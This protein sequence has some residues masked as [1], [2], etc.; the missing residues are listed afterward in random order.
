MLV[1]SRQTHELCKGETSII[2]KD[3]HENGA[4]REAGLREGDKLISVNG[5]SL[6]NVDHA[7]AVD[8][9]KNE[10]PSQVISR[11]HFAIISWHNFVVNLFSPKNYQL[12]PLLSLFMISF[13]PF[14]FFI[15]LLS[16]LLLFSLFCLTKA[17]DAL[18]NENLNRFDLTFWVWIIAYISFVNLSSRSTYLQI[19]WFSIFIFIIVFDYNCRSISITRSDEKWTSRRASHRSFRVGPQSISKP[20]P[21]VVKASS[22]ARFSARSSPN[23]DWSVYQGCCIWG[24][25]WYYHNVC[26][27]CLSNWCKPSHWSEH[28]HGMQDNTLKL[29]AL[30]LFCF[31][32]WLFFMII[33]ILK[34]KFFS[35][36][37]FLIQ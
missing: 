14:P 16:L 34:L 6:V 25:G 20:R 22:W 18:V 15:Y 36:W 23:R 30:F 13:F 28:R 12:I 1:F 8:I 32:Q 27:C 35:L 24:T 4:A 31:C 19:T 33:I 5:K 3:V 37:Y 21:G 2:I 29:Y 9:I 11:S 26:G 10:I 7:S 17:F